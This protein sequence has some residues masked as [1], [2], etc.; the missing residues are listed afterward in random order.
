MLCSMLNH[1]SWWLVLFVRYV[2]NLCIPYVMWC[3][4]MCC[5]FLYCCVTLFFFYQ[6]CL[7]RSNKGFEPIPKILFLPAFVFL[8]F[9]VWILSI[10][11]SVLMFNFLFCFVFIFSCLN[12]KSLLIIALPLSYNFNLLESDNMQ[13][14]NEKITKFFFQRFFQFSMNSKPNY[15]QINLNHSFYIL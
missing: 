6:K 7:N 5:L 2:V 14:Q 12:Q 1:I 15:C 11:I 9:Q 13:Q 4:V 8:F 3:Y 10:S